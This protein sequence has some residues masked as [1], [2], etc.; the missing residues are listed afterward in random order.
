[1]LAMSAEPNSVGMASHKSTRPPYGKAPMH[2][3]KTP[4]VD[5]GQVKMQPG[6]IR[7]NRKVASNT[8]T[9]FG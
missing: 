1:M 9:S 4:G 6:G 5:R 8:G 7:S 3:G 2:N